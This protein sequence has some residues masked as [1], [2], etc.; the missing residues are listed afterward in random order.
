MITN[1]WLVFRYHQR[2]LTI[3]YQATFEELDPYLVASSSI[4]IATKGCEELQLRLRDVVNV[5]YRALNP[6]A[7]AVLSLRTYSKL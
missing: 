7:K 4:W 3:S 5:V 1:K 2:N 6:D